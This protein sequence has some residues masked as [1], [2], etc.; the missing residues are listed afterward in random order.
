MRGG[1]DQD[2]LG[3]SAF[4]PDYCETRDKWHGR[5]EQR[6]CWVLPGQ[7]AQGAASSLLR[8]QRTTQH[9][10]APPTTKIHYYISSLPAQTSLL[11]AVIR[12]HW[13]IENQ[14]HWVLDV[15]YHED[16]CRTRTHFADDNLAVLRKIAFNLVR[17]HPAKGSLKG[18]RYRAALNEDF[19]F[20]VMQSPFNLMCQP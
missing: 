7:A 18:K 1:A 15:V 6:Q 11:L 14:C 17:Q 3:F 13:G 19:L 2:A 4:S 8:I 9:G 10:S 12:A 20:E 16:A 5:S